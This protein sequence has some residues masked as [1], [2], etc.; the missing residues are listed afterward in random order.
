MTKLRIAGLVFITLWFL[1]GGIGHFTGTR[2]FVAIVPPYV[3]A[4]LLMV[5]VSGA[6][7]IA[8]ALGVWIPNL[9]RWAGLGLFVL[10]I[11]VTPANI[12][13]WQHPDLFPNISPTLLALRLPVQ[14]LLLALIWWA[15]EIHWPQK[16]A[17]KNSL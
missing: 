10:T 1:I 14:V 6:F 17:A 5:Y 13:M 15:T 4:P 2:F 9:R 11:C 12:Y 7:E 3:P 16:S 8:G